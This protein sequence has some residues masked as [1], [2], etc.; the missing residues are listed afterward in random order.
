MMSHS[1][2]GKVLKYGFRK[3]TQLYIQL[4]ENNLGMG[5]KP[6]Y[7]NRANFRSKP[8]MLQCLVLKI[9]A[10]TV[11]GIV[12]KVACTGKTRLMHTS[13]NSMVPVV[14]SIYCQQ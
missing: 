8:C 3:M 2:D 13:V 1:E 12:P 11:I 9:L 5:V 4:D 14:I 10:N 6:I 7:T